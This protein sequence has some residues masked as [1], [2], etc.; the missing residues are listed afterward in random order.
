MNR[1]L[2]NTALAIAV[3]VSSSAY[4]QNSQ[5]TQMEPVIVVGGISPVAADEFGRSSTV[6]NKEQIEDQGYASV[7]EA[8]EA[9][10]GISMNGDS[11]SN[12]QIRVRGGEGNH[13]L[14]LI[15]GVR[16]GSGDN[17]YYLRGLDVTYVERIEILR[18]PQAV[19]YGTDAS[20]GV[21]NIVTR[22][23][24]KGWNRGVSAELGG[25]DRTAGYVS[26]GDE[27][28]EFSVSLY[29]KNDRGYDYSND[30]GERDGIR[31]SGLAS[32][33][34]IG[35]S[36][37]LEFAY[38]ARLA[39]S[40]YDLDENADGFGG[41]PS[42]DN[43]A[44]YVFDDLSKQSD[45]LER[46]LSTR[47]NYTSPDGQMSQ[48]LRFDRTANQDSVVSDSSTEIGSYRLQLA[49]DDR[50][51]PVSSQLWSALVERKEDANAADL[52]DRVSNSLAVEYQG[53]LS[54]GLSMQAGIRRDNNKSFSNATTWNAAL[55]YAAT[56]DVRF[57]TSVGRAIVN[58]SFFE[59]TGGTDAA[60]NNDLEPEENVGVDAGVELFVESIGGS[61]DVTYFREQLT[62]EI[63]AENFSPPV[64]YSNQSGTSRR[65]GLEMSFNS[66]LSDSLTLTGDYTYLDAT[67]PDGGIE[68][69][70]PRNELRLSLA[71][72][73]PE[74]PANLSG[75]LRHVR[76]LYD[77]QF[78]TGGTNGARLSDFTVV[79]LAAGYN[80]NSAI[81]VYARL[82]NLFDQNHK[83]VW[84]YA[85][86]GRAG[87]L[88]VRLKW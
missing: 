38:T 84:G 85:S 22:G 15:D 39:E 27:L 44:D 68:I 10:P 82:T 9:Q 87:N 74:S 3:S 57:H 43:E 23:A 58:P 11:P 28:S 51:I 5:V 61:I 14:V 4:A 32:K 6:I 53:W 30:G 69:R 19:P 18:G 13:V 45:A 76:G 41:R 20:T 48:R 2:T 63:V 17:E 62:D 26:Y 25:G 36:E 21:I 34:S 1:A 83:E 47:L 54:D 31:W 37:Q 50:K 71:W 40:V 66:H 60:L 55:S 35:L 81:H 78:W 7:Q 46:A 73:I 86:R 80:L 64:T 88:G 29:N 75:Q 77:N 72:D 70:R 12:R 49:M 65:Q 79:D 8:L 16:A 59:F 52:Q 24:G 67:D 56:E 33:G 42:S